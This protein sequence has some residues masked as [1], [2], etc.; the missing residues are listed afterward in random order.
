MCPDEDGGAF[1]ITRGNLRHVSPTDFQGELWS[2]DWKPDCDMVAD[3]NGGLYIITRGNLRHVTAADKDGRLWSADWSPSCWGAMASDGKGGLFVIT[4]GNLRHVTERNPQGEVWS[5]DWSPSCNMVSD[6]GGGV[7]IVTRGN[8]RHATPSDKGGKELWSGDWRPSCNM[9]HDGKDGLFIVT[10]GNLRHAT[11]QNK[12][13]KV[14]S[15]D[16]DPSYMIP[17]G[18]GGIFVISRG[19][20]RQVTHGNKDG[21]LWSSDWSPSAMC[22][23]P[24]LPY[25]FHGTAANNTEDIITRGLLAS[26]GGRIG[27]G[28]YFTD[29]FDLAD[30]AANRHG[31]NGNGT[32]KLVIVAQVMLGKM[33]DLGEA[34]DTAGSWSSTYESATGIHPP[35]VGHPKFREFV[36]RRG[37]RLR[38]CAVQ[39]VGGALTVAHG[40][41]GSVTGAVRFVE[42]LEYKTQ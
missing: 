9:V 11:P 4:R 41:K 32:G 31:P 20:L 14:W 7:F 29:S 37:V 39:C 36:V 28:T 19:N 27:P 12:D 15:R 6:G 38:I 34:P 5:G 2:S 26:G 25:V 8:L 18:R 22:V 42:K 17:D 3:G 40:K 35:W 1:V 30:K 10:R 13:G 23:G 24:F 21:Y 16:W 33:V